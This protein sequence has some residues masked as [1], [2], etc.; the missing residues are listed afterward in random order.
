MDQVA[1]AREAFRRREWQSAYEGFRACEALDA[2][3]QD[4][5]A[6]SAHWLGHAGEVVAAYAEAYRLHLEAGEEGR[7]ALSAFMIAIYRRLGGEGAQAD[8][9]Q[10]R[11]QRL[12]AGVAE[13]AEHGYPLYLHTAGLLATDLDAAIDSARR[14]QDLGRR[15][16]DETLVALG[17]FFEGRALVK[18]AHVEEGL[19]LLDEAMLAA[20]SDR[21][22]PLW[23]GAIYCGLL[24]ACHELVDHRRAREWTQATERWCSPL[25]VASL[26]PGICRVHSADMLQLHGEWTRAEAEALD[27]CRDMA[28]ID[29][30]A[31][32][33]AHYAVGEIRR[34][35]GDLA[36]AQEA[37]TRSHELGRDP[38]PGLALLRLAQGRSEAASSSIGAAV[39][40]FSG[41]R[42]ER[43]L[44]LGAQ[45]QIALAAGDLDLAEASATELAETAEVF[46]SP[47][48]RAAAQWAR[49]AVALAQGRPVVAL[50][51]LRMAL[52]F[53]QDFDAPY[54]AARTR[55]LLAEAYQALDDTDAATRERAAAR[56][57]F[58]RLGAVADL[59]SLDDKPASPGGL[60]PR[61]LEVLRLVATGQTNR[62]VAA[63]LFLSEKTVA[64]HVSNIFT[65]LDVTSRSAAT[66]FAYSNGLVIA[67]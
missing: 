60:S 51:L 24:D 38:Q 62:Q 32:A 16:H 27:V 26:Y 47:G 12:L 50:G 57:C 58:E 30:F 11:A 21:L 41:S 18:Q 48:L 49:G 22:K 28:S 23:T 61:E 46:D 6:E 36:G 44:L 55:V 40:S 33:D 64:R 63:A 59:G 42:L 3:D 14:M 67:S 31:A 54:D 39:A 25:P 10:A 1:R 4:S 34:R 52:A 15:F 29:V 7:A 9:W 13:G 43:A 8:G 5:L 37:Y 2:D 56:A 17:G 45:V 20:L 19:A 65:K 53:W 35:R 66:A